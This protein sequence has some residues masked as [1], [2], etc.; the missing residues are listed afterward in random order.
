VFVHASAT[1]GSD[2]IGAARWTCGDIPGVVCILGTGSN[3]ARWDGLRIEDSLPSLGFLLGDEGSGAEL[4]K[5]LL[6]AFFYRELPPELVHRFRTAYPVLDRTEVLDALYRRPMPNRWCAEFAFFYGQN[7][8]N[9]W[10]E[11]NLHEEFSAFVARR[12]AP[13]AAPDLPVHAVGGV[14]W[15]FR[16]IWKNCLDEK[17][18]AVGEIILSPLPL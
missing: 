16:D 6:K 17:K 8:G 10:I 14:A 18:M 3:A 12:V 15:H 9:K 1:I 11:N 4:G 5:R 7:R 2:L 13:L